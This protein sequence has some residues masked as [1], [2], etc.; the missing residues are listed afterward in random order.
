M[1]YK[2]QLSQLLVKLVEVQKI[3]IKRIRQRISNLILRSPGAQLPKMRTRGRITQSDLWDTVASLQGCRKQELGVKLRRVRTSWTQQFCTLF[4]SLYLQWEPPCITQIPLQHISLRLQT[5]LLTDSP[6]LKAFSGNFP[7]LKRA[8]LPKVML[9]FQGQP[10][11]N[12]L[13]V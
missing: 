8:T 10:S 5:L 4:L 1:S 2:L 9:Y 7:K 11:F 13:S 6:Q 3:E 12:D